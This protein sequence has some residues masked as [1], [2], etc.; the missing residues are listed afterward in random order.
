MGVSRLFGRRDAGGRAGVRDDERRG[1]ELLGDGGLLREAAAAAALHPAS[2][3]AVRSRDGGAPVGAKGSVGLTLPLTLTL[4][5]ILTFILT[6]TRAWLAENGGALAESSTSHSR[7]RRTNLTDCTKRTEAARLTKTG[8]LRDA[9][10][11]ERLAFPAAGPAAGP[12]CGMS[13]V[14]AG[15]V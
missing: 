5:F 3:P 10:A 1:S 7:L 14:F 2:A 9:S 13:G 6:L 12:S 8:V 4:T 15:V 11:S